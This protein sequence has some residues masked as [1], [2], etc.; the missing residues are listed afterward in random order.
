MV[1][2]RNKGAN[3][4]RQAYQYLVDKLGEHRVER[5]NRSGYDGDDLGIDGL[6]SV[7]CKN[8]AKLDLAGWV[9]QA[10]S[11]APEGDVP[12]VIHKRKGTTDVGEHYVTL[13]V[14]DLLDLLGQYEAKGAA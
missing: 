3:Y 13:T 7:E 8:H 5:R 4:E 14:F 12:I 11:Q 10:K 2:S 1:H 6:V 9:H